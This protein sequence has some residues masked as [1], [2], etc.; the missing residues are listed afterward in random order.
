MDKAT[1]LG[2]FAGI[3]VVLLGHVSEGGHVGGLLQPGAFFIVVGGTF[4]AMLTQSTLGDFMAGF[5]LTQWMFTPPT[6]DYRGAIAQMVSWSQIAR[7][8]SFLDLEK[9]GSQLRDP[10]L[11]K[12]LRMLVNGS[13]PDLI[14]EYLHNELAAWEDQHHQDARFWEAAAGYSPTLGILGAV[15]GL[16]HT[17]ENISDPDAVG[18]GIAVAFVAT[19]YGIGLANLVYLPIYKKLSSLIRDQVRLRTMQIEGLLSIAQEANPRQV[20]GRMQSHL[21][22]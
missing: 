16:I 12:G 14:A 15:L 3:G 22:S 4:G 9:Q 19:I 18:A 10:F 13:E 5:R 21:L 17:M 20:E 6:I 1:I 2:L 7:R 11:K 8:G